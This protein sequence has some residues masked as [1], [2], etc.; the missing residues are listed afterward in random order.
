VVDPGTLDDFT[1]GARV[2][3]AN[4]WSDWDREGYSATN[5]DASQAK[6]PYLHWHLAV[7]LVTPD[8]D[9]VR[10]GSAIQ[11]LWNAIEARVNLLRDEY[12]L[13][14]LKKVHGLPRKADTL[15]VLDHLG[16]ARP[17]IL[18]QLKA[19]RNS[20]E[21][22]DR[23]APEHADCLSYIDSVW[24]FLRS[25]DVFAARRILSF[26]RSLRFGGGPDPIRFRFVEFDFENLDWMPTV[27]GRVPLSAIAIDQHPGSLELILDEDARAIDAD[28]AF[29]TGRVTGSSAA[30]RNIVQDYF[31][32]EHP[33]PV[34]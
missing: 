18:R 16:L 12:R 33:D 2:W 34:R 25:T 22:Q 9:D 10:R 15:E 26:G 28:N 8:A 3:L 11:K 5:I 32:V 27:R 1:V 23:G 19:I 21:H 7:E 31:L 24:Y 6:R 20:V 13:G 29:I 17:L 14:T 4:C 30:L